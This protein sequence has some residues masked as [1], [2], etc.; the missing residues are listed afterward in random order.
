MQVIFS[1]FKV[2][3]WVIKARILSRFKSVKSGNLIVV[4]KLLVDDGSIGIC[5]VFILTV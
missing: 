1:N 4:T 5:T 2:I 3:N